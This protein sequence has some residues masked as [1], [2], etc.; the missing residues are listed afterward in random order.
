MEG[1]DGVGGGDGDDSHAGAFACFDTDVGVFDDDAIFWRAG[2]FCCGFEEDIWCGFAEVDVFSTDDGGE[3]VFDADEA[4]DGVEIFSWG[5]RA[6]GGG[7]AEGFEFF[8]QVDDA[9]EGGD[10]VTFDD[11][12]VEDFFAVA[13]ALC[14]GGVVGVVEESEPGRDDL[15]VAHAE[16]LFEEVGRHG[17]AE[18][19]E[20]QAPAFFVLCV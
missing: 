20:E 1:V 10:A 19:L 11:F 13:K 6:D 16:G 9:W 2:D 5:G 17:V 3:E 14:D 4:H 7:D 18:F 8:E 15:L 12:S